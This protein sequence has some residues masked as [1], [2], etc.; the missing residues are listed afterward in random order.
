MLRPT[1]V[2]YNILI[3]RD[4]QRAIYSVDEHLKRYY[5]LLIEARKEQQQ[6]QQERG[7]E[8]VE[9]DQTASYHQRLA[10]LSSKCDA[11]EHKNRE[12]IERIAEEANAKDRTSWFKRTQ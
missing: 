11:I 12:A 4:H 2:P 1:S 10:Y 5:K 7:Q 3:Y 9:E 6:Q 8:I